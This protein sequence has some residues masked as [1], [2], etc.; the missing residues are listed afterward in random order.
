MIW[1]MY[2]LP[3]VGFLGIVGS[4]IWRST[5]DEHEYKLSA[6]KVRAIEEELEARYA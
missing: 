3:I 2:W 1:H 6:A 5:A 4:I